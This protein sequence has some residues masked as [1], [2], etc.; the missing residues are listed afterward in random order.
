MMSNF[1]PDL[2]KRP[3]ACETF[4]VSMKP[5]RIS[6]S[7]KQSESGCMLTRSDFGTFGVLAVRIVRMKF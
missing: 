4:C 1:S 2:R 5:K 3:S 6:S 7:V